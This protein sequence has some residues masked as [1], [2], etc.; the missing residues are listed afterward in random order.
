MRSALHRYG[1]RK[2]VSSGDS[3]DLRALADRGV[4]AAIVGMGLYSGAMD[5]RV[6]A[7]EFAE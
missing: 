2:T 1:E 6:V 5:P 7:E 3:D 4:A